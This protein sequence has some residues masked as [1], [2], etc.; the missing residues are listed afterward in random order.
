MRRNTLF[1]CPCAIFHSDHLFD[2]NLST[3]DDRFSLNTINIKY[4]SNHTITIFVY[5]MNLKIYAKMID[6]L[7]VAA[8]HK[9]INDL[10]HRR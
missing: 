10:Q 2:R 3:L 6:F 1:L 8:L 7:E 4:T 5:T 9:R